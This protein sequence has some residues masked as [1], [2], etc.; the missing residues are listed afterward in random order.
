MWYNNVVVIPDEPTPYHPWD[1]YIY[2]HEW[3][4][5]YGK[6]VGKYTIHGWYGLLKLSFSKDLSR[7][8]SSICYMEHVLAPYCDKWQKLKP[9][10]LSHNMTSWDLPSPSSVPP[11]NNQTIKQSNNQTNKQTTPNI[12][13]QTTPNINKTTTI[14]SSLVFP[15]RD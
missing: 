6:L 2:L 12:N 13:K 9:G 15:G 11:T 1:W 7:D 10:F 14:L 8:V 3:L 5:F 4:I